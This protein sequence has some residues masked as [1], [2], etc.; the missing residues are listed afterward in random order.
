MRQ[1]AQAYLLQRRVAHSLRPSAHPRAGLAPGLFSIG[2]LRGWGEYAMAS[3]AAR[4]RDAVRASDADREDVVSF[5]KRHCAEGRL[6]TDELSARVEA[7]YCAGAVYELESLTA[8]LPG[9][10]FIEP[11]PAALA[12]RSRRPLGG[13]AARGAALGLVGF[14]LVGL[15]SAVPP[16]LSAPLLVLFVPFTVF[17]LFTILPFVLP[18]LALIW[19]IRSLGGP[20]EWEPPR[21]FG[22]H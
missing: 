17:A 7:A 12:R 15:A 22:R 14:A 10:P 16:E 18:V 13:L 20:I 2:A 5:L 6:S 21:R 3:P 9:T 4:R 1:L 19:M 8:D 11:A